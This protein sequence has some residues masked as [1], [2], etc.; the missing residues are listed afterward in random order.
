MIN[1]SNLKNADCLAFFAFCSHFVLQFPQ[2]FFLYMPPTL[3]LR[4]HFIQITILQI[5][6]ISNTEIQLNS[7]NN[8]SNLKDQNTM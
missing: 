4:R 3:M 2:C 7:E 6:E 1:L 5:I 8:I